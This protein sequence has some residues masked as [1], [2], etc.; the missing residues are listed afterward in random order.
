[1]TCQSAFHA[2]LLDPSQPMP[3][4][5]F[6]GAARPAGKRYAVYR[7]NVT[8][9]LVDAMK[10]AFPLVS[11][12]I[13]EGNFT[14]LARLYVRKHP[15]TSPLM[16]FYGAEF[17]MF[18]ADFEPLAHIGYLP[19]AARLDL[20]LRHSYHAADVT[21]LDTTPLQTLAPEALL[22]ATI[23]LAPA[24][25][26]LRSQWP[27]HDIWTFNQNPDADKPRSVAQDVLITRP[28]F[29]PEPHLLPP[30]AAQWMT[31][32]EDG[33]SLGAAQDSALAE[34]PDFDLTASLT[35]ALRTQAFARISHKDLT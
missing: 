4:G 19:D 27:L 8:T 10:A 33:S 23:T 12:L 34:M 2:G 24:T 17:P 26:I 14:Q 20:E 32:L 13:G 16:M 25:R 5:L 1:M 6:D 28:E 22:E 3:Q 29:D 21:P 9:S 18:L 7:N 35:L 30:G 15:P 31:A 11:K